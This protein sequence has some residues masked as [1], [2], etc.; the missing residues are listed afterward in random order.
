MMIE[1]LNKL[2]LS[3][4]ESKVYLALLD[5]GSTNAGEVIKKTKLHRNIVYDNLDRLIEKG[6]VSFIKIKNIKHFETTPSEEF[7]EYILKQ[8][9]EILE[10][11]KIMKKIIPEI[12]SEREIKRKQEATIYKGKKAIK[13]IL[14]E[15][16]KTKSELLVFGTGWGAKETLRIYYD[17][18]HCLPCREDKDC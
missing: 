9:E 2:G 18:W 6:L 14:D 8:K 1:D 4:N 10:K 11:E 7:E 5:L 12:K 15:I 13:V 17:Q 16:T 3:K